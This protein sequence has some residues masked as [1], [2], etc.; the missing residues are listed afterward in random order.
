MLTRPGELTRPCAAFEAT[1][2]ARVLAVLLALAP[3]VGTLERDLERTTAAAP[4]RTHDCETAALQLLRAETKV[5]WGETLALEHVTRC[6]IAAGHLDDAQRWTEWLIGFLPG[7]QLTLEVT[8]ALAQ[9][10]LEL[11]RFDVAAWAIESEPRLTPMPTEQMDRLRLAAEIRLGLGQPDLAE[12]DLAA[13]ERANKADPAA[14]A[15]WFWRRRDLLATDAQRLDHARAYLRHHGAAGGPAR[16]VI[17]ESTIGQVLWDMSCSFRTGSG[18]C[19]SRRPSTGERASCTLVLPPGHASSRKE[20]APRPIHGRCATPTWELAVVARDPRLAR[21]AQRHLDQAL[22]LARAAPPL[23][24]DDPLRAELDAA[25]LTAELQRLDPALE[26]FVADGLP[27]DLRLYPTRA[28]ALP[29]APLADL[30]TYGQ[31]YVEAERSGLHRVPAALTAHE[32]AAVG[33][34]SRFEAVAARAG[35]GPLARAAWWRSALVAEA[36]AHALCHFRPADGFPSRALAERFFADIDVRVEPH[37]E[38]ARARYERCRDD[39]LARREADDA[40]AACEH[41]LIDAWYGEAPELH[42]AP[43]LAASPPLAV[44]I[45]LQEPEE[46]SLRTVPSEHDSEDM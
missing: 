17:A 41:G 1:M 43:A 23:V 34:A 26:S 6:H 31:R 8:R 30:A 38:V 29:F 40:L 15:A 32:D 27:P 13:I 4:D 28:Q 22:R 2:P 36:H 7:R 39:G 12:A 11:A 42:G 3:P 16:R 45:Q 35:A 18:P 44:G 20:R 25:V 5:R 24:A 14:A 19:V 9:R 10:S 21:Q 46:M 37:R 33:L